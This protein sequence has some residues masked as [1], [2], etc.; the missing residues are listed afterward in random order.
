MAIRVFVWTV[1]ALVLL[2][3][4]D[5]MAGPETLDSL[6]QAA[7]ENNRELIASSSRY[8]SMKHEADAAGALPDPQ[9]TISAMDLPRKTLSLTEME[10]SGISVGLSQV[11]PWPSKLSATSRV[12]RLTAEMELSNVKGRRN[13]L[14]RE[15]KHAYYE[16]SYWSFA[17]NI[18]DENI[19]LGEDIID[20]METRYS[21]GR[22]SLEEVTSARVSKSELDNE[23]LD[24]RAQIRS[25]VFMLSQL[26]NDTTLT[27]S[28]LVPFLTLNLDDSL[29]QTP[30][31]SNNP[32]LAGAA[33]K[34]EAARAKH[35][36][37]KSEYWPELMVGADYLI[38]KYDTSQVM[39]GIMFPGEDMWSFHFGFTLPLWFFAKQNKMKTA[40]R[41]EI[42]AA[43]AE[44]QFVD[45]QL[46]QSV[47]EAQSQLESLRQRTRHF[48][49]SIIPLSEAAY[50]SGFVAY[51]VGQIDFESLLEDQMNLYESKLEHIELVKEYHQTKAYLDEL[52]GKEY[53][54]LK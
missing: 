20:F 27:D 51:E 48:I 37:A 29:K 17:E 42:D 21:T 35:S 16:Y 22:A 28:T 34:Y 9:F 25:A 31:F 39:A 50:N 32:M 47:K 23:K 18:I 6:I 26:V 3:V 36:L 14:V 13:S 41:Y 2:F 44:Q 1:P 5:C 54:E 7:L 46:K 11:I 38:R 49:K 33:T 19:K 8:Q 10:M 15:I 4:A 43:R 12:S 52:T 53:G 30:D 45:L 24:I 40:A